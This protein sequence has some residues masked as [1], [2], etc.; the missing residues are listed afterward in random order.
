MRWLVSLVHCYDGDLPAERFSRGVVVEDRRGSAHDL[1]A[2]ANKEWGTQ[3]QPG[4]VYDVVPLRLMVRYEVQQDG[5]VRGV[6]GTQL[7]R[8][9]NY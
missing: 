6:P 5:S 7:P 1:I 4:E 2:A 9:E 8:R 3:P